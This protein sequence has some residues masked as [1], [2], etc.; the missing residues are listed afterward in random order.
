MA[1]LKKKHS[2]FVLINSKYVIGQY[3]KEKEG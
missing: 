2:T 3:F 1:Y